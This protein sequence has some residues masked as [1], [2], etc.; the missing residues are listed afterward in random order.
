MEVV[1]RNSEFLNKKDLVIKSS[2]RAFNYGDGFF[3]TI[4]IINSKPFNFS[5]HYD[6]F[7]LACSVL[8][9]KNNETNKSLY[10][11][12]NNL[13]KIILKKSI[14]GLESNNPFRNHF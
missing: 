12:I 13:V 7:A 4:K 6:R 5:A 10:E 11:I 2:N 14:L 3:E 9:L 1:F 8:K